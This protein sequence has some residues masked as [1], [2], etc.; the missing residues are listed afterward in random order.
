M[1]IYIF[2][3]FHLY[4]PFTSF[5]L[6]ISFPLYVLSITHART[7]LKCTKL[8]NTYSTYSNKNIVH[9]DRH[10][11]KLTDVSFALF[12][13]LT[14]SLSSPLPLLV[15]VGCSNGR[16]SCS[17]GCGSCDGGWGRRLFWVGAFLRHIRDAISHIKTNI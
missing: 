11:T 12:R 15:A 2:S 6:I 3:F 9:V 5:S 17:D 16:I 1:H 7:T 4:L 8:N 14:P 10:L 13:F